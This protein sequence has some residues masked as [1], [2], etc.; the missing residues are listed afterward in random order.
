MAAFQIGDRIAVFILV[1]TDDALFHGFYFA[2][3]R[4]MRPLPR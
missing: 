3:I 1:E 4:S 2:G